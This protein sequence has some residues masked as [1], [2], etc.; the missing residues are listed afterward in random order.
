MQTPLRTL[1]TSSWLAQRLGVSITT[2]ERLR[3][4]GP[5]YLPPA[6]AIGNSIRYDEDQVELWLLDRQKVSTQQPQG[7]NHVAS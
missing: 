4:A 1:K 3:V 2:I 5:A 7:E 6:I